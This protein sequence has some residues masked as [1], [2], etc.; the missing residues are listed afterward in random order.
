MANLLINR[1]NIELIEK[2]IKI[3][4][5]TENINNLLKRNKPRSLYK[6]LKD[7]KCASEL[8]SWLENLIKNNNEQYIYFSFYE[9]N[10]AEQE[11]DI[12]I[13]NPKFKKY[14]IKE[15]LLRFFAEKDFILEPYVVGR[16]F[17]VYQKIG[18]E[19][20]FERYIRYDF[21][22][23][24]YFD[25]KLKKHINELSISIGSED[26]YIGACPIFS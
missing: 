11:S 25:K 16:D 3:F 21:V 26:V 14:L 2:D 22:I 23:H 8:K 12:S 6:D 7:I 10:G 4:F 24:C 18:S 13:H 19:N 9:N 1:L 20:N 5:F 17:C 15:T